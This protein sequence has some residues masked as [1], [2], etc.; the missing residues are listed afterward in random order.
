M[1]LVSVF[2]TL[3]AGLVFLSFA[4][5]MNVAQVKRSLYECGLVVEEETLNTDRK[6]KFD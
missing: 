4:Y 1:T 2:M 5:I 6:S 3:I